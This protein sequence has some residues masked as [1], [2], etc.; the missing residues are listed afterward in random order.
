MV[1]TY[2]ETDSVN[3]KDANRIFI[4]H[5]LDRFSAACDRAEMKI[6]PEKTESS[7]LS[8]NPKQCT[9]WVAIGRHQRVPFLVLPRHPQPQTHHW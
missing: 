3:F 2:S 5:A 9:P 6:S 8:R 7:Y 1:V 4:Q